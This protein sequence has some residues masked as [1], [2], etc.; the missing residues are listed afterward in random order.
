MEFYIID[1]IEQGIAV[2]EKNDCSHL[3]VS[4]SLLPKVAKEGDVLLKKGDNWEIDEKMTQQR[5]N[6]M[7]ERLSRLFSKKD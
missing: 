6:E 4:V 3:S 5:R 2:L 7:E 1:R